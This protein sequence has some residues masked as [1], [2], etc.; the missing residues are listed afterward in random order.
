MVGSR[1]DSATKLPKQGPRAQK[2]LKT[3]GLHGIYLVPLIQQASS[4]AFQSYQEKLGQ[5]QA[6]CEDKAALKSQSR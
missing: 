6:F 5:R 4:K 2:M 1:S 3:Q